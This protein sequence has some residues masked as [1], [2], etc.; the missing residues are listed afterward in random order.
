[1]EPEG[2][3]PV[4]GT[5]GYLYRN[6]PPAASTHQGVQC[7]RRGAIGEQPESTGLIQIKSELIGTDQEQFP[8]HPCGFNTGEDWLNPTEQR[9]MEA[10][11]QD[12]QQ[13]IQQQTELRACIDQ[14]VVVDHQEGIIIEGRS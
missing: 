1:M 11:R 12:Q 4:C 9:H 8:A 6:R 10:Q 7:C 3:V 13:L 2:D 14:L 5:E